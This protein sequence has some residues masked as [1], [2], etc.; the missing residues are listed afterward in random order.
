MRHAWFE[1]CVG[2][3]AIW[4]AHTVMPHSVR[5]GTAVLDGGE[6]DYGDDRKASEWLMR[7]SPTS[8]FQTMML[9]Y[10]LSLIYS[11]C[12][13]TAQ[14]KSSRLCSQTVCSRHSVWQAGCDLS[15]IN[16]CRSDLVLG[17]AAFSR[18]N[19]HPSCSKCQWWR[20]QC[21]HQA[22]RRFPVVVSLSPLL[23]NTALAIADS[24]TAVGVLG[25]AKP[26]TRSSNQTYLVALFK[27]PLSSIHS[28]SLRFPLSDANISPQTRFQIGKQL[29]GSSKSLLNLSIDLLVMLCSWLA[30]RAT[31]NLSP[32]SKT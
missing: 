24:D 27:I 4:R 22:L 18:C 16:V 6:R 2:S 14:D 17:C 12:D 21:P 13:K 9:N 23:D 30:K 7:A 11:Y 20:W 5:A 1:L 10:C 8:L 19:H 29:H 32:C 26:L 25:I 3:F 31:S 28:S 15:G